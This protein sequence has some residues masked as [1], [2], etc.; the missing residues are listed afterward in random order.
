[1]EECL[2]GGERN[3]ESIVGMDENGITNGYPM[4]NFK[5][6]I[7]GMPVKNLG[8]EDLKGEDNLNVL[9][10]LYGLIPKGTFD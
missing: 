1:M 10:N 2:Q 9:K 8:M 7:K 5:R 6:F 4:R 3:I